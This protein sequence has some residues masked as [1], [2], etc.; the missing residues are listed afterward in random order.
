MEVQ[1]AVSCFAESYKQIVQSLLLPTVIGRHKLTFRIVV[2]Q[3]AMTREYTMNV[4]LQHLR[5]FRP[6]MTIKYTDTSIATNCRPRTGS[7]TE[8]TSQR[9]PLTQCR[10]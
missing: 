5:N 1:Y 3:N 2:A 8:S 10:P 4:L 9:Y 7:T 6:K